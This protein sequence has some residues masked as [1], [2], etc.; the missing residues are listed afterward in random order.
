M[1]VYFFENNVFVECS[2][3][4]NSLS[5]G[6][7]VLLI[8]DGN[9]TLV[10]ELMLE[11]SSNTLSTITQ[12]NTTTYQMI[13]Y[14]VILGLDLESNGTVG[15]IPVPIKVEPIEDVSNFTEI[16]SCVIPVGKSDSK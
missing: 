2:F 12:C 8:V 4:A 13:T 6:C 10:E 9:E 5:R 3:A 14:D 11:R 16:T 7:I 15:S 1:K